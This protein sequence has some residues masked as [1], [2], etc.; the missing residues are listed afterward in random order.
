MIKIISIFLFFFLSASAYADNDKLREV[1]KK[2]YPELPIK[3][4]KKTKFN[5]L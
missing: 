1:M 3:N 2:T 4:I 5:D